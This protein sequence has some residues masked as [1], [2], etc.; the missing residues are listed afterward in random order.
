MIEEDFDTF[1][2]AIVVQ[3]AQGVDSV[4]APAKASGADKNRAFGSGI[5]ADLAFHCD[6]DL[7]M[8]V[9]NKDPPSFK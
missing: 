7:E 5:S 1:S 8:C 2:N 3:V 4:V 9:L 6:H